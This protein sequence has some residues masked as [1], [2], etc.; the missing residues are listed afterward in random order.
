V[1]KCNI[2]I[3]LVKCIVPHCTNFCL[4]VLAFPHRTDDCRDRRIDMVGCTVLHLLIV[5]EPKSNKDVMEHA[6][7][8]QFKSTL[9]DHKPAV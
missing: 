3:N 1:T 5:N 8:L 2:C 4:V 9:K 6:V 7:V